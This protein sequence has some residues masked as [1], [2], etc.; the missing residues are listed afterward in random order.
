MIAQDNSWNTV[1]VSPEVAPGDIYSW[2]ACH[3]DQSLGGS[4][5]GRYFSAGGG[6]KCE[7]PA[8]V[9][10]FNWAVSHLGPR[11]VVNMSG[12]FPLN[13]LEL[14]TAV[15]A[16]LNADIVVVAA[17]GNLTSSEQP[18]VPYPAAISGVIGVS[19]VR[20]DSGFAAVGYPTSCAVLDTQFGSNYGSFVSIAA[21]FFAQSTIPTDMYAEWCGTSMSSPYVA[22]TALLVRA[23]HPEYSRIDVAAQLLSTAIPRSPTSQYGAG[24]VQADLAVGFVPPTIAASI[25]ANKPRMTWSQVPLASGYRVYRRVTPILAPTWALWAELGPNETTYLDSATRVTSFLGYDVAPSQAA[26]WVS[27]VVVSVGAGGRESRLSSTASYLPNGS[28]IY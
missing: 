6:N 17:V 15:S 8:V 7:M 22:G 1:G 12:G 4:G 20:P 21:P 18:F 28:P 13:S 27:Y 25:Q 19:G 24:I 14:S 16:A 26:T 11:G 2:G 23:A 10:A 5:G 9:D 3:W